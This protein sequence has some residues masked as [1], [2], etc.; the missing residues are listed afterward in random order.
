MQKESL[1]NFARW[2]GVLPIAVAG[3]FLGGFI[4]NIFFSIQGWFIGVDPNSG[5][6][7]INYWVLS[8]GI[9]AAA[10]VYFG[11]LVAPKHHKIVALVLGAIVV[12][13]STLTILFAFNNSENFT[14][15]ILSAIS[16]II[17]G[18]MVVHHF[19]EEKV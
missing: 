10:C 19:Y 9:S 4:A 18:G 3:L 5:W 6:A 2:I 13:L 11:S 15:K 17:A 16:S 1:K 14:W 7:K 12:G 8:F